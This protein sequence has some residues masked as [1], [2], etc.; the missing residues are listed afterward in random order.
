[1]P[2]MSL[3]G[4]DLL[5]NWQALLADGVT[6]S[7]AISIAQDAATATP[8]GDTR[9]VRID[10]VPGARTH[11]A[12][13]ALAAQA[14]SSFDE[15]RLSLS[16][17]R[18]SAAGFFVELRIGSAAL[19]I[20]A[21]GNTWHRR[22]PLTGGGT[23][24]LVR[25]S[26]DD[27]PAAVRGAASVFELHCLD[28]TRGARVLLD[29]ALAVR[30]RLLA[31]TEQALLGR[32]HQQFALNGTPVPASLAT[33]GGALPAPR[34]SIAILPWWVRLAQER[35]T[36]QALRGDHSD[37]GYRLRPAPL[38]YELGFAVEVLADPR[39]DQSAIADFVLTRLPAQGTLRVGGMA[40]GVEQ[41]TATPVVP[42]LAPVQVPRQWLAYRV[43]AWQETGPATPVRPTDEVITRVDWKE[44]SHA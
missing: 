3:P 24:D 29:E 22:V 2:V 43:W 5:A 30:P 16:S 40:L 23:W 20:G 34:P 27:L 39:A 1:M 7:G 26:L 11:I 28:D 19:A 36:G 9:S 35:G 33:A 15:L 21:P 18:S 25:L 14:L 6:P 31:D 12:R 44:P 42:D 17:D 13:C 10:F 8:S 4:V 32:L 37:A 38:A 41:V